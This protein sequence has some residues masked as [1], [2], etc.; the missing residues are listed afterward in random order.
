[1]KKGF[2]NVYSLYRTDKDIAGKNC[3]TVPV[4]CKLRQL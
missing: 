1:M 2:L 4:I 3:G